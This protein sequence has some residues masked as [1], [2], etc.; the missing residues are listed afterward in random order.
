M[1]DDAISLEKHRVVS[2]DE[3]L[4]ARTSL[5]EM[6][7]EFTRLRDKLSAAR[8]ELPWE[9]VTKPY[10]FDGPNGRESLADLFEGRSQLIVYHFMFDPS[11]SEGCKSCSLFADTFD[12]AIRHLGGRDTAFA[13]IS[14]A[15]LAKL[16]A[17]QRRMGWTFPWYSSAD[18]D[19]NYDFHVTFPPEDLAAGRTE[20]NYV[21]QKFPEPEAPGASVFLRDGDQ[22]FHT[23]STYARGLDGLIATYNLLDLTPLGRHEEG[24]PYTM[25]WV[26]HHDRYA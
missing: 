19:F 23:Y 3:W 21:V 6:E 13:A 22:I 11:W 9:A 18:S 26:R 12:G 24:L 5:L 20:Y 2:H 10:V 17:F 7:K 15:P 25:S 1:P 8:R 14:R 4:T 16:L